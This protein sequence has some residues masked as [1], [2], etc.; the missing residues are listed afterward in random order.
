MSQTIPNEITIPNE[1]KKIGTECGTN[2]L[3]GAGIGALLSI[4]LLSFV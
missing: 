1:W 2:T 3:V 4:V